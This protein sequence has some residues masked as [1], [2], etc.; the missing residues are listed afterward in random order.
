MQSST[1]MRY[2]CLEVFRALSECV[3]F[4]KQFAMNLRFLIPIIVLVIS[5]V[6]FLLLFSLSI[7]L[8]IHHFIFIFISIFVFVSFIY[9]LFLYYSIFF[10]RFGFSFS[11]YIYLIFRARNLGW[12]GT[13]TPAKFLFML[14]SQR[15]RQTLPQFLA[16][17]SMHGN[18]FSK[19]RLRLVSK[20]CSRR[21]YAQPHRLSSN[22]S[23]F[24]LALVVML[25]KERLWQYA[26][27]FVLYERGS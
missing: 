11:W 18:I 5:I 9:L 3:L 6:I 23:L 1:S 16:P 13:W 26:S 21:F 2:K 19:T 17:I 8:S 22:P 15:P 10:F 20:Q 25:V 14:R 4:T 12:M 27:L 24:V 7:C